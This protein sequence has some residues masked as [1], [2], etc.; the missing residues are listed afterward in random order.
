MKQKLASLLTSLF[1]F[2]ITQAQVSKKSYDKAVDYLNCTTVELSLKDNRR[3][4]EFQKKCPCGTTSYT[5]IN[6]FLTSVKLDE[7]ISLSNEVEGLKKMFKENW[8]KNEAFTFLSES[9][10]SEKTKYQNISKFADRRK[11]KIELDNYKTSLKG[12]LAST[13]FESGAI[14]AFPQTNSQLN[15]TILEQSFDDRIAKLENII[16]AKNEDNVFFG[17]FSDYLI[18]FSILLSAIALFLGFRKKSGNDFEMSNELK[19]YI[20]EKIDK[21]INDKIDKTNWNRSTPNI[22]VGTADLRDA[23]NRIRDLESQIEKI[24]FQ[25]INLNPVLNYTAQTTQTKI[26]EIKQP[27]VI[28]QTFFLSTPNSDGSF[29][30]KYSS[31]TYLDGATI[32]RF[33]KIGNNRAKFQIDEKDASVRLA[34]QYP[35]KNIEPVCEGVNALNPKATRI[36]TVEQGEA[37]LQNGKWVVDKTKKAKIKYED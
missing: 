19:K 31:L 33:S 18:I 8:E 2:G 32:Y 13:L 37:E 35:D 16:N 28:I 9:V 5:Q 23:N 11:G 12:Y 3:L 7:T 17:G 22:N 34:L 10:F 26:Q 27:E 6:Q 14:E 21:T 4:T 20:N 15:V 24:K 1:L 36:T 30:E 29:N 25:L